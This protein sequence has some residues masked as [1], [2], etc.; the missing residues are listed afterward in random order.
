ME[1]LLIMFAVAWAAIGAY[2]GRLAVENGRLARR[3]E[4]LERAAGE[5]VEA[6][7]FRSRVA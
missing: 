6:K 1:T 2:A 4:Q 7:Q 3:L 5:R